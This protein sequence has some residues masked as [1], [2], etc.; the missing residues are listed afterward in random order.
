MYWKAQRVRDAVTE[1][2]EILKRNPDDLPT[3]R[4]WPSSIS[5]A[6]ATSTAPT[7]RPKRI[8]KAIQEYTAVHRLDLRTRKLPFGSPASTACT[9]NPKKPKASCA[10]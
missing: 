10:V 4:F 3:H 7:S 5:A 2:N 1:A 8:V 6:L 9:T